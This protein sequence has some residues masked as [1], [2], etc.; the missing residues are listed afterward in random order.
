ME[1]ATQLYFLI[2]E[3]YE[4]LDSI[5]EDALIHL[6]GVYGIHILKENKMLETCGV[7]NGRQL[8]VL[9]DK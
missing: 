1:Y 2:K 8:Y 3:E 5:Y 4:G 6:I 9:R 7:I